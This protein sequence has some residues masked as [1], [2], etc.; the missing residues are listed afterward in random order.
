MRG[1]PLSRARGWK[2]VA[3]LKPPPDEGVVVD[4]RGVGGGEGEERL[5]RE[6]MEDDGKELSWYGLGDGDTI[7]VINEG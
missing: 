4:G 6:E 7:Q 3:V 5:L 1:A 2:L